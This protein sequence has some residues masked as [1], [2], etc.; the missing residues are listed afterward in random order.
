MAQRA[1]EDSAP[2]SALPRIYGDV[3]DSLRIKVND[4]NNFRLEEK[5]EMCSKNW[6]MLGTEGGD[7][8]SKEASTDVHVF[9]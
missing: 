8:L 5:E 7:Q 2:L 3:S 1:L 4:S 6:F 9:S